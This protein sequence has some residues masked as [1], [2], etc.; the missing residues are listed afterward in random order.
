MGSLLT[1]LLLASSLMG[2][3]APSAPE[4]TFQ[5]VREEPASLMA[6]WG[7]SAS[8]VWIVG[9][10]THL[11]GGPTILRYDGT[12]WSEL[13]SGQS[14][15]DLWWV[16]GFDGH[17]VFVSGT[18][19]TI[20]RYRDG[21]FEK[22]ATPRLAG[23]IFGMWGATPNDLW[24]VGFA[25]SGGGFVWRYDGVRWTELVVPGLPPQ[26][27][28]VHGR[29][30]DDVW[31]SCSEGTVL[32]W[33]G[34]SLT[35]SSTG[36]TAP[37]FSIVTISDATIAIGGENNEGEIVEHEGEVW[38]RLDL[39]IPVAWRGAAAR[40]NTAYV[41][42]ESGLIAERRELGWAMKKQTLTQKNFHSAW[43]DPDGGLWGVGGRFDQ[44]LTEDGFLLY[45]GTG[46]VSR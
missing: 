36:L 29:A 13:E 40:G 9:G 30:A 42:G 41:V 2:C 16:F 28:K 10:R 7:T 43:V 19:G 5:L 8:D 39:V 44:L 35:S 20:L 15:L 26:V 1:G 21:A 6:V 3:T 32:H 22:M 23:T 31:I 4:E 37:L 27:F 11:A 33:N 18:G 45:Y 24:A 14:S 17:D 34:S 25:S 38:S 46:E 12:A